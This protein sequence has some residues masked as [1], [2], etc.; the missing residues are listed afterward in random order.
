[1][2]KLIDLVLS[3]KL[4]QAALVIA[5][6]I[7]GYILIHLSDKYNQIIEQ[8]SILAEERLKYEKE[9]SKAELELKTKE[10]QIREH[11]DSLKY[12]EQ[13]LA[14]KE[15]ETNNNVVNGKEA[16]ATYKK[17]IS[18]YEKNKLKEKEAILL[19]AMDEFISMGVDLNRD[20]DCDRASKKYQ[21]FNKAKAKFN[22]IYAIAE[23]YN[24]KEKYKHFFF[25]HQQNMITIC[26]S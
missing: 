11:E 22:Q 16:L 21:I 6:L 1:M 5:I 8:K 12:R 13:L 17:S 2:E 15:S 7:G 26:P 3:S 24:L 25:H 20:S 4:T 9:R 23:A 10:Y 18:E 14:L 19:R